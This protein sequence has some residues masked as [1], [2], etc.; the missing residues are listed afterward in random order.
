MH[1]PEYVEDE[2]KYEFWNSKTGLWLLHLSV[3]WKTPTV[4]AVKVKCRIQFPLIHLSG[5]VLAT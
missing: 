4:R 3:Q 2:S 1:K 5:N